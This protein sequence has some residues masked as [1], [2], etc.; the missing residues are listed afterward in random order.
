MLERLADMIRDRLFWK[1][2]I[3]EEQRPA[4]S[5][6]GGGFTVVP[7]MMSIVGCSGED[8]QNILI[9]LGYRSQIKQV[10]KPVQVVHA[11]PEA[12]ES[13]PEVEI[14]VE[15]VSEAIESNPEQTTA[16]PPEMQDIAIWWP[17]G[18]GPFKARP[19]RVEKPRF[20]K[21]SGDK[22]FQKRDHKA[23]KKPYDKSARKP[24]AK[25]ERPKRPEKPL[26]PNSPFAALAALKA[27]MGKS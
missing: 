8:F 16:I 4:G 11:K 1:P 19:S 23:G 10:P 2:R 3:P 6:E 13:T 22:P 25:P 18:M 24:E 14:A 27:A 15:A 7:D 21:P 12:V 9:S 5:M 26:D 17:D 20:E